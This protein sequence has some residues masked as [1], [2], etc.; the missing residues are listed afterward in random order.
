ML[1]HLHFSHKLS[2]PIQYYDR[3]SPNCGGQQCAYV[4]LISKW[5]NRSII[6]LYLTFSVQDSAHRLTTSNCPLGPPLVYGYTAHCCIA[7]RYF[8]CCLPWQNTNYKLLLLMDD[9]M[10]LKCCF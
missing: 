9:A 10:A 8:T 7:N 1:T 6:H 3:L 4:N 2:F 5:D